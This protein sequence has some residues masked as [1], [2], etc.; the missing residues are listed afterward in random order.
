MAAACG[1]WN[2]QRTLCSGHET[3]RE[4]V[5]VG[6]NICRFAVIFAVGLISASCSDKPGADQNKDSAVEASEP[7]AKVAS[8]KAQGRDANESRS[9]RESERESADAEDKTELQPHED[10][11]AE[12]CV[13][14]VRATKAAPAANASDDC[15]GCSSEATEVLRIQQVKTDRISCAP[16]ACEVD[17]TI[18]AFF[19]PGAG[20]SIGGG[21][22][23]WIS[24]EQTTEYL[25]G[26][27]P[28]G[29]QI[30]HVRII[31]KRLGDEWRAIEFDR[32]NPE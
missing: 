11:I 26:H 8:A 9:S 12:D 15:P 30:Y 1:D 27:P 7:D 14:F 21:L 13:D 3:P 10:E 18:G 20:E 25:R 5:T 29:E 31:Y 4:H 24:P 19:N 2:V 28:A 23:G 6:M 16:A 32:A 22:T 17:V